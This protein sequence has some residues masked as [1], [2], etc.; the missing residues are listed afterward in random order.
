MADRPG[1]VP[2]DAKRDKDTIVG[3]SDSSAQEDDSDKFVVEIW[4]TAKNSDGEKIENEERKE[5][6]NENG[7]KY[8]YTLNENET[9]LI[10]CKSSEYKPECLSY[11]EV[12]EISCILDSRKD[13][14]EKNQNTIHNRKTD[15]DGMTVAAVFEYQEIGHYKFNSVCLAKTPL[16][17][18][19][20]PEKIYVGVLLRDFSDD[21]FKN[22][23]FT[24]YIS[25][26]HTYPD[27][28]NASAFIVAELHLYIRK[29]DIDGRR[30]GVDTS[31]VHKSNQLA[32][33]LFYDCVPATEAVCA[34]RTLH[35]YVGCNYGISI[36]AEK[37]NS[38]T[39]FRYAIFPNNIYDYTD[40]VKWTTCDADVD[41]K[42]ENIGVL[43]EQKSH[44]KM[45]LE[46]TNENKSKINVIIQISTLS[47]E[48]LEKIYSKKQQVK[49]VEDIM[50]NLS[51]PQMTE[52][53]EKMQSKKKEILETLYQQTGALKEEEVDFLMAF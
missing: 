49:N 17:D 41:M 33:S 23:N 47:E 15:K 4:S 34:G 42:R 8:L 51:C 36:D 45:V 16:A 5:K 18:G 40:N 28:W 12:N 32:D 13:D 21:M 37:T 20:I 30:I 19:T 24:K 53:V 10:Y 39:S 25:D 14:L 31:D 6:K 22:I 48:I 46:V 44:T 35:G 52:L 7:K 26:L 27:E 1:M 38:M 11:N 9:M 43:I 29:V 50:E 2:G 3:T